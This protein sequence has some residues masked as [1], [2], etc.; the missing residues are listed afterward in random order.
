M[1]TTKLNTYDYVCSVNSQHGVIIRTMYKKPLQ[2]FI[3]LDF[4]GVVFDEFVG[5]KA[6]TRLSELQKDGIVIGRWSDRSTKYGKHYMEYRLNHE[7]YDFSVDLSSHSIFKRSHEQLTE[8]QVLKRLKKSSIKEP[9]KH[10]E[11]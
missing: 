2:W 6:G 11:V 3:G 10:W 9:Q 7:R 5:Y 8:S 1:A 4:M